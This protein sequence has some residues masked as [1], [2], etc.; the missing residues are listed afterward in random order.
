MNGSGMVKARLTDKRI[1]EVVRSVCGDDVLPLVKKLQ[2]KENVS[3]FRLAEQLKEDIKRVRNILYRLYDANLV[4]FSRKKDKKKGWYIYY[5]T[6]KPEQIKFL[7]TKIKKE[8]LEHIRERMGQE[9]MEQFFICPN[10]CVRMNFE[11]AVNFEYR[12][13]EC[14]EL[15]MQEQIEEQ[16]QDLKKKASEL[17]KELKGLS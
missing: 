1:E 2:G 16:M 7:F 8:Q 4:E 10:R 12:C 14:G 13:P 11:Q 15:T 5:W 3:E 6:F 17:E 9:M